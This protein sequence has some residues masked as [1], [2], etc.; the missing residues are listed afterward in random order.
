MQIELQRN[1]K[2]QEKTEMLRENN[3]YDAHLKQE[4]KC[5]GCCGGEDER[6]GDEHKLVVIDLV[7]HTDVFT[8]NTCHQASAPF[9]Q[10]QALLYTKTMDS[11]E[12]IQVETSLL[13]S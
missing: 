11:Y 13:Y 3:T 1:G 8:P 5:S 9:V 2:E 12:T 4:R 7:S 10:F 6:R